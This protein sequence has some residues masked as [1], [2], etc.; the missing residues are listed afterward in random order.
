MIERENLSPGNTE[1]VLTVDTHQSTD[2]QN[3]LAPANLD[4]NRRTPM[5][6]FIKNDPEELAAYV[7]SLERG[8][9]VFDG[10]PTAGKTYLATAIGKRF[11]CAA[12]TRMPLSSATRGHFSEH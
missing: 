8:L 5:L 7:M 10:R 12:A 3:S 2:V 4:C 6:R 9:V 11:P 1:K